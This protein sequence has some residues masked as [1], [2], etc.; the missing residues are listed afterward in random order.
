MF[1]YLI[2]AANASPAQTPLV[3]LSDIQDGFLTRSF[4]FAAISG[5]LWGLCIVTFVLLVVMLFRAIRAHRIRYNPFGSVTD[6][7]IIRAVLRNAFDQRRPFEIQFHTGT[8]GCRPTLRCV[9]EYLGR[10]SF[11]LEISWLKTLSNKWLG[12]PAIVFFRV[13][14][15]QEYTYYTLA[16]HLEGIHAPRQGICHLTLPIPSFLENRQK[17]SFLRIT[18]PK[19][20]LL[21]AA[22]W[23]EEAMPKD[24]QLQEI[25]TWPR[26]KL[27][28]LPDRVEQF[29]LLDISAGGARINI[30]STVVRMLNLHFSAAENLILMLDLFDLEQ[31][32]RLRFWMQC[33]VQNAWLEHTSHNM[34]I[35]VQFLSWA[36]PK[37]VAENSPK[38]NAASIEWLRLSSANEVE[39]LGNWIMRRHLEIFRETPFEDI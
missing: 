30:P 28:L 21:G 5:W 3:T 14:I 10:D 17:R 11:T 35:G 13:H 8:E 32:K 39:A 29:Q 2:S 19:E 31:N 22:I 15:G 16:S 1:P 9:P 34:H 6:P 36:R 7:R 12:R 33:R 37:D 20:F 23:Y 27:L 18:P 4:D 38:G 24:E 25:T 26:P